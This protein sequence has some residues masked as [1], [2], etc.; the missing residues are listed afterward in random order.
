VQIIEGYKDQ[1]EPGLNK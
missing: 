1:D